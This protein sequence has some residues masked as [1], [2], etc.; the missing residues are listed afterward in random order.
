MT[1]ADRRLHWPD[2]ENV[3][4]LGGLPTVDGGYIRHRALVR[5]DSLHRLTP[6]GL[7]ALRGYGISRIIDLRSEREAGDLPGPLA[8][9][10]RYRLLPLVDPR[11]DEQRDP[12]AETT[13]EAVYRGS[14][15]RNVRNIVAG[16]AAIADAPAGPVLVHCVAGKDR[17]GMMVALALRV[18]GARDGAIAADY[19][20]TAVCLRDR[21]AAE[22]AGAG[23]EAA[24]QRLREGQ[25]S[26]AATIL[27][28]LAHLDERYGDVPRYLLAHGV[29]A[30]QLSRLRQRLR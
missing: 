24:R 7:A 22:L 26:H 23:D 21:F 15:L 9:D 8:S 2:C 18:A 12:A 11:A 30:D 28:M 29:S 6:A 3:R 25:S 27:G 1:E 16:I 19:A 4:D 20:Y 14:A 17:T 5:A 10:P 13:I